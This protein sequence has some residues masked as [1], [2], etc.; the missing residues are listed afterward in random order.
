LVRLHQ[1]LTKI[2]RAESQEDLAKL[3]RITLASRRLFEARVA[4]G[5]GRLERAIKLYEESHTLHPWDPQVRN[6][7]GQD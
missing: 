1:P 5:E 4:M 2:V 6:F 7:L 3:N